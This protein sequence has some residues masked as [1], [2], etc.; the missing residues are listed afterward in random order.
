MRCVSIGF[1]VFSLV[2]CGGADAPRRTNSPL[3]EAEVGFVPIP[4]DSYHLGSEILTSGPAELFYNLQPANDGSDGAPLFVISGGGPG[5]AVLLLTMA[6]APAAVLRGEDGSTRVGEL[7]SS[8]TQLG[9][10]LFID[11]RCSGFS[12]SV[13]D[14]RERGTR[15]GPGD[16]NVFRDAADV[17]LATIE[18]VGQHPEL[19]ASDVVF[20]TES[21]GG[22][23]VAAL[24]DYFLSSGT[25]SPLHPFRSPQLDTRIENFQRDRL[26][27]V[28][29]GGAVPTFRGQILLQPIIAGALQDELAGA[30]FEEPGS[31]IDQLASEHG[32]EYVRCAEQTEPC[33][34]FT[35]AH[36]LLS[37]IDVSRYDDRA[38]ASWLDALLAVGTALADTP[39]ALARVLGVDEGEIEAILR[40]RPEG[41][42]RFETTTSDDTS[43]LIDRLGPLPPYDAFFTA[44]NHDVFYAMHSVE[45]EALGAHPDAPA[46]AELFVANARRT[47]TLVTRAAHDLHV[48]APAL[49][50]VLER[51]P[52]VSSARDSDSAI[53][54]ALDDGGSLVVDAPWFPDGSHTV[55]LDEPDRLLGVLGEWI[56]HPR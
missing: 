24:L 22:A 32:A 45:V 7:S 8:L 38:R 26:A 11:A 5:A 42:F 21:Y 36:A 47:P 20:V 53:E 3:V 30:L 18:V 49:P 10:L 28:E 54:L 14:S 43:A 52:G 4:G 39:P 29:P 50:P 27:A 55:A 41:A 23:R 51:L 1:L 2:G 13:A 48:Y 34:P 17:A 16:F 25:N 40:D 35:N 44:L 46:L 9:N 37:R 6:M 56:A 19:L 15:F 33:D 31:I 12:Y